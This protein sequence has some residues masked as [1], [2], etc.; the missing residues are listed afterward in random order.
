NHAA[1]PYEGPGGVLEILESLASGFGWEPVREMEGGPIIALERGGAHVS[2]EPGG[3]LELSG[4][5]LSDIHQIRAATARHMDELHKVCDRLGIT[6]L[7]VG[8]HPFARQDD[9]PWVPK[10][11][12]GIMKQYLPTRGA[13]ALDMMRRT[14]TVQANFDYA[15]EEDALRKLRVALGL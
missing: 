11:R 14:A 6:W 2:L 13:R 4:A 1:L 15:S 9:L 10:Q 3:Q 12:Y 8:F 5:P 7:G